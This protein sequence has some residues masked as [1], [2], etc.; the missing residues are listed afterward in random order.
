MSNQNPL[1]HFFR[2]PKMY[3]ELPSG[4]AY[5]DDKVIE[6]NDSGEVAVLAMTAADEI[7]T[8]NP[9]ALL[10]GI[11]ISS[12]I[13]SCVPGVKNPDKLL[14]ADVDAL[15]VAIRHS[16]Y[17]DD[18]EIDIECPDCGESNKFNIN[19]GQSLGTVGKLEAE[20]SI[21]LDTGLSIFIKPYSY[22]DTVTAL[23]AQFEQMKLANEMDA[24]NLDNDTKLKE[25]SNSFVKITELNAELMSNCIIKIVENNEDV[26]VTNH[27]HIL[28]YLQNIE[29][30]TFGIIDDLLRDINEIGITKTF[31]AKCETCKHEW[32]ADIDFNP[33]NFFTES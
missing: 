32:E 10:N 14:A 20:Y 30:K 7:A 17:G 6:F 18:I 19:I 13:S 31:T 23:R 11:A 27:K 26:T 24:N 15:M 2:T 29:K 3:L 28:Q 25:L 5:Y 33:V 8:K 4:T 22:A 16:T 1:Q 21:D 12:I 9:D